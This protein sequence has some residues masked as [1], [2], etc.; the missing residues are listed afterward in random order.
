MQSIFL[1]SQKSEYEKDARAKAKT[2]S[3]C[4]DLQMKE[5]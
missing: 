3:Q 4:S 1:T 5:I 2:I